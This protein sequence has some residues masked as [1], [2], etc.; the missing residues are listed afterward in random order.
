MKTHNLSVT[1]FYLTTALS[2]N[3]DKYYVPVNAELQAVVTDRM[4]L[5]TTTI[6]TITT[7]TNYYYYYYYHHYH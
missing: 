6:T 5:T 1:N 4:N 7:T 3:S 2:S